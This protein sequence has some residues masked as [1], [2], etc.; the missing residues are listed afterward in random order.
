MAHRTYKF[1]TFVE[2]NN[3]EDYYEKE[4][5]VSYSSVTDTMYLNDI[6]FDLDDAHLLAGIF[7]TIALARGQKIEDI[8]HYRED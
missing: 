6:L 8:E 5:V 1:K 2:L 3:G 7:T 4:I